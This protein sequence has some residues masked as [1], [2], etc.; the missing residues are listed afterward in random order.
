MIEYLCCMMTLKAKAWAIYETILCVT[1]WTDK[2][3]I[4]K[5]SLNTKENCVV[6]RQSKWHN[7]FY[8][9][10]ANL[11]YADGDFS[12]RSRHFCHDMLK[13]LFIS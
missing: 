13:Q 10:A 11:C 2:F 7:S 4:R 12:A 5:N 3:K 8:H 1:F 6:L 9:V